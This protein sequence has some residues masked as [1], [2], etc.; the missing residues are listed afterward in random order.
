MLIGN[1][2]QLAS[3]T[4]MS[5]AGVEVAPTDGAGGMHRAMNNA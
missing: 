3:L 2:E 5:T 1:A 4:V